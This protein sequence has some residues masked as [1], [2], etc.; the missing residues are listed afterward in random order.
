MKCRQARYQTTFLQIFLNIRRVIGKRTRPIFSFRHSAAGLVR[1]QLNSLYPY[2]ISLSTHYS[3]GLGVLYS[4]F[5]SLYGV[6]TFFYV[7]AF[8][9]EDNR[10]RNLLGRQRVISLTALFSVVLIVAISITSSHL[11]DNTN[12]VVVSSS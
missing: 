8:P 7:S 10:T 1:G 5:M 3:T 12:L 9:A 2:P 11:R 6:K 4:L